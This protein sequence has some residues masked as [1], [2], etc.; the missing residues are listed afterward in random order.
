MV[1][2]NGLMMLCATWIAA[3]G[4]AGCNGSGTEATGAPTTGQLPLCQEP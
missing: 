4:L 3:V 2:R 1:T